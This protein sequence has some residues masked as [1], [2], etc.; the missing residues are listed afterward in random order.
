MD[1]N[2]F[3]AYECLGAAVQAAPFSLQRD[4]P[5]LAEFA[6]VPYEPYDADL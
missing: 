4:P 3:L 2:N 1:F 6:K 5:H